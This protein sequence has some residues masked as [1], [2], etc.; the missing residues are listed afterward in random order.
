MIKNNKLEK[1][2]TECFQYAGTFALN[3]ENI[4]INHEMI[5]KIFY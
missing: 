4:K 2:K 3:H 1:I 5:S